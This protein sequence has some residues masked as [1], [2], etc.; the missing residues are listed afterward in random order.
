MTSVWQ[1]ASFRGAPFFVESFERTGGRRGPNHEFPQKDD[2][3][4]EDTG[5]KMGEHSFEAYVARS[6]TDPEYGAR[7]DALVSA[8][9]Q[10][11][12]GELSHPVF[13][14]V[15]VL[16]REWTLTEEKSRLGL[17]VFSLSF[18]E[19][20]QATYP[21][22]RRG[23]A[24]RMPGLGAS[25]HQ[26]AA[27]SFLRDFSIAGRSDFLFDSAKDSF[28]RVADLFS[29]AGALSGVSLNTD[30][31]LSR[32][33]EVLEVVLRKG[34]AEAL[35]D[36]VAAFPRAIT[37]F[38]EDKHKSSRNA[39][40]TYRGIALLRGNGPLEPVAVTSLYRAFEFGPEIAEPRLNTAT[41]MTQY[42]NALAI[43][44]LARRSAVI[45]AARVAPF[46]NWRMLQEAETARDAI[47]DALEREAWETDDD[48]LYTAL[49]DMRTLI[50]ATVAPDDGN[51]PYLM[52]YALVM[53]T[54]SLAL[55][56][57]LY[58]TADKADELTVIN[59]LRHP[60]F[61]PGG[62]TIRVLSHA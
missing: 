15:N 14:T 16:I 56:H 57:S 22:A 20:G 34:S 6:V 43:A 39:D 54:P 18:V 24:S 4:A 58:G 7:R 48:D 37:G 55:S 49:S 61:F 60:G 36:T 11:G 52:D 41:R 42:T 13:G 23:P 31:L 21:T 50:L 1:N 17:A 53:T 9:N 47:A 62:E 46:V 29:M 12:P 5:G 8:L 19:A 44:A 32:L 35:P 45:E 25:A 10:R 40:G 30:T 3:Y 26:A 27:G 28:G 59:G 33:L 2:G 51:L 38:Y